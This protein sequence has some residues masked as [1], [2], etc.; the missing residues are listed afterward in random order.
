MA[1][2]ALPINDSFDSSSL[3]TRHPSD[4]N[5]QTTDSFACMNFLLTTEAQSQR[6]T[7]SF[8]VVK[9]SR[10]DSPVGQQITP[11]ALDHGGNV[12]QKRP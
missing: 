7:Q 1:S 3:K 10:S 2:N 4:A 8:E 11:R 12:L 6:M 5:V 9:Y